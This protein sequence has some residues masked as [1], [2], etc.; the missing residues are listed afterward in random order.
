MPLWEMANQ[1]ETINLISYHETDTDPRD[2]ITLLLVIIQTESWAW[3][4]VSSTVLSSESERFQKQ[5]EILQSIP[6]DIS[7]QKYRV[8]PNSFYWSLSDQLRYLNP[9][10]LPY[11]YSFF[12]GHLKQ[13]KGPECQA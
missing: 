5:S 3:A 8:A 7:C 9:S 4:F 12:P 6:F 1:H 2:P 11:A 13:N 10:F